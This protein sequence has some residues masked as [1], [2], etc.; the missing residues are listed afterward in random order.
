MPKKHLGTITIL[1]KDRQT[2]S[3]EVNRILTEHGHMILSRLGTNLE[4]RCFEH[5]T[6]LV[7]VTIEGTSKEIKELTEKIDSL[8]GIVAKKSIVTD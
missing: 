7:V 4:R 3:P 1:V 6:A 8:Y 2:N 5:C